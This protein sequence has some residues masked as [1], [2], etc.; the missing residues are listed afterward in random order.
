[1]TI[2]ED[3]AFKVEKPLSEIDDADKPPIQSQHSLVLD[4]MKE[5]GAISSAETCTSLKIKPTRAKG[6]LREMVEDGLI[7]AVGENRNRRYSLHTT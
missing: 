6:L 5:Y 3:N 7:S 2:R 1:M 4:Y